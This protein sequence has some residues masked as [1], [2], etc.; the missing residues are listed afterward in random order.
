MAY[1]LLEII[2]HHNQI[3]LMAQKQRA[4]KEAQAE[5]IPN[6]ETIAAYAKTYGIN[7]KFAVD[8]LK[9][10]EKGE[11]DG[12]DKGDR[13]AGTISKINIE[14][15]KLQTPSEILKKHI[16][17]LGNSFAEFGVDMEDFGGTGEDVLEGILA[18]QEEVNPAMQEHMAELINSWIYQWQLFSQMAKNTW[19][20]IM[21]Y[22]VPA[23]QGIDS[24]WD[25]MATNQNIRIDNEQKKRQ[26][27]IDQWYEQQKKAIMNSTDDEEERARKLEELEEERRQKEAQLEEEMERKRTEAKRQQA[28]RDKAVA[29][30]QA[31][32][33]TA[34]AVVEALPNLILA[35]LVGVMGAAQI[36]AIA[37]QPIPL[38][39]G[40]ILDRPTYLAGEAGRE[41]VIPL[42]S[43]RGKE[44]LRETLRTTN[45][46]M[47]LENKIY[48]GKDVL[49][50][51]V[52]KIVED[53]TRLGRLKIASR[54]VQ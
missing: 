49:R 35:A 33:N 38:A 54:A 28:K 24:V 14:I 44:I 25:Q 47:Y 12:A 4:L 15:E 27:A 23:I 30:M 2:H 36:A 8:W 22:A 43:S 37:S 32:V 20:D 39:T 48:F 41:A 29:L 7:L 3:Y 42:E 6:M 9:Q 50:K 19:Y 52:I 1:V 40:G 17:D 21:N 11:E 46:P 34:S 53:E 18:K 13:L 5:A 51:E 45:T 16:D 26:S 10:F 31:T